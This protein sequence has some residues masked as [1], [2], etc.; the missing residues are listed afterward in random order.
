[1]TTTWVDWFLARGDMRTAFITSLD[2]NF[3]V[4]KQLLQF[5]PPPATALEVGCG[6]GDAAKS[7]AILGYRVTAIDN[8]PAILAMAATHPVSVP[9]VDFSLGDAFNPPPGPFDLATSFGIIEHFPY[10]DRQLMLQSLIRVAKVA[11]VVIP[12]PLLCSNS[13]RAMGERDIDFPKLFFECTEAGW[14]ILMA[15]GWG[16]PRPNRIRDFLL[17][18]WGQYVLWPRGIWCNSFC[19][20]GRAK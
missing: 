6:V 3:P 4:Y 18:G 15:F 1:M 8:D 13:D 10:A 7:L 17:K 20:I 11:C 12:S 14:S 2:Y 5:A 19:V 16:M 9:G